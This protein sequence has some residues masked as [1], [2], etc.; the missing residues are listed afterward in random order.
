[1]KVVRRVEEHGT[2]PDYLCVHLIQSP[3]LV[4]PITA[5]NDRS[6]EKNKVLHRS[7][8]ISHD[9]RLSKM[10]DCTEYA[11]T[12]VCKFRHVLHREFLAATIFALSH[13]KG[14]ENNAK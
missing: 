4:L 14:R 10:K 1:M 5:W 11:S 3:E 7:S 6:S 2:T 8:T 13:W 9:I 12:R